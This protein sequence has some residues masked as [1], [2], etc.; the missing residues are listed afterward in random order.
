MSALLARWSSRELT[1]LMAYRIRQNQKQEEAEEAAKKPP[2]PRVQ[3]HKE[4]LAFIDS[5]T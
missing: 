5:W 2:E 4:Q 3:T 1:E